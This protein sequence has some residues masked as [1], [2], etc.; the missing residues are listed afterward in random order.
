MP[1]VIL[2]FVHIWTVCNSCN[3][4]KYTCTN[5]FKTGKHKRGYSGSANNSIL[6][7]RGGIHSN[8]QLLSFCT[9][10]MSEH[11]QGTKYS[12]DIL[13]QWERQNSVVTS[14]TL[15]RKELQGAVKMCGL[16]P[17]K[18]SV[19]HLRILLTSLRQHQLP[20]CAKTVDFALVNTYGENISGTYSHHTHQNQHSWC[21]CFVDK[22]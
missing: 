17:A 6:S 12:N 13:A 11:T 16:S 10:F 20:T 3:M 9:H 22:K 1:S 7:G 2:K 18:L 8:I 14:K 15:K 21:F 4:Q 19:T 5:E